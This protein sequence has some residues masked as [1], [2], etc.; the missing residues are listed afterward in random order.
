MNFTICLI[1]AFFVYQM[2]DALKALLHVSQNSLLFS[3][4]A[5]HGATQTDSN[6]P[7]LGHEDEQ[8]FLFQVKSHLPGQ[9]KC[10]GTCSAGCILL[11]VL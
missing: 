11:T 4:S 2:D 1:V 3:A 5:G 9:M 7:V 10:W 8:G 6:M